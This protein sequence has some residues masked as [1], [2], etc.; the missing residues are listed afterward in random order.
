MGAG[1]AVGGD[2]PGVAVPWT[3]V[4]D[5][6][7]CAPRTPPGAS[8]PVLPEPIFCPG[9]R[10]AGVWK[11]S[12]GEKGDPRLASVL[13]EWSA[14][15]EVWFCARVSPGDGRILR[16]RP[17]PG[18][19]LLRQVTPQRPVLVSTCTARPASKRVMNLIENGFCRTLSTCDHRIRDIW[20]QSPAR[21]APSVAERGSAGVRGARICLLVLPGIGGPLCLLR[22]SQLSPNPA[23]KPA[24]T[25]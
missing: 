16:L 7:R 6:R 1:L 21:Q 14:G 11:R 9:R 18:S 17:V 25:R 19:E 15:G 24:L 3:S 8:P 2:L 5:H 22:L 13:P 10:F 4:G 20:S 23:R 12:H